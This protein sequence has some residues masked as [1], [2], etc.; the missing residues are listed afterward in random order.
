MT[1]LANRKGSVTQADYLTTADQGIFAWSIY[2]PGSVLSPAPSLPLHGS[3]DR[4]RI[5]TSTLDLEDMWASAVNKAVTKIAVRGYE[6]SDNDDSTRRTEFGKSL[7]RDLDGPASYRSGVAKVVQDFLLTDNGWFVEVQRAGSNPKGK[8]EALYHLDSFRCY[9]TGNLAYPVVYLDYDGI[10]HKLR[11]DQVIFGSDM[12]S[13]RSRLWNKGR[14]AASRAFQTIV[15]LSAMDV[16]FQEK[17]TGSRALALHFVTGLSRTQLIDAMDTAEAEKARKGHVV[18]KGAIMIPLQG[19]VPIAIQ[20]LDLASVPDGFDV[21]QVQRDGYKKYALAIGLNPDELVE[22]A[23]GLNSGQSAQVAEN[24]AEEA[25]GLPYFIK[26]FEDQL[27]YLVMPEPTIFQITTNDTRDKKAKADLQ[28]TIADT[29]AVMR[30]SP[31]APGWITTEMALQMSVD[32]QLV[33]PEFLPT[34]AT[35]GAQLTDSGDQSK[36]PAPTPRAPYAGAQP[37][38]PP[39][40]AGPA[41][42]QK[43]FLAPPDPKEEIRRLVEANMEYMTRQMEKAR[44][45]ATDPDWEEAVTWAEEA[46]KE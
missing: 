22:R 16:Y 19:D 13:P 34:D 6:I 37:P 43:D 40:P 15:K 14:C 24:A 36:T 4:D 8:V 44:A 18:Y 26:Q 12:P 33:P 39:A 9:R 23:A 41:P 20:S 46:S 27:N 42:V 1:D 2:D 11:P 32:E 17:I 30:G 3:R 10:F 29:I 35:P 38:P 5:L 31:T 21:E 25:G 45:K 7:V 28:K